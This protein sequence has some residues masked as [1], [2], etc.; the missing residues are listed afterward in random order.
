MSDG[1]ERVRNKMPCAGGKK[2]VH[3]KECR[4]KTVSNDEKLLQCKRDNHILD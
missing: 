2:E 3:K 4:E 1:K